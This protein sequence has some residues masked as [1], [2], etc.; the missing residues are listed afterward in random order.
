MSSGGAAE[1]HF[2]VLKIAMTYCLMVSKIDQTSAAIRNSVLF[3][4]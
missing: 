1:L 3:V 4:R 2:R